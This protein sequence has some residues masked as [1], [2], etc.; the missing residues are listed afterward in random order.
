MPNPTLTASDIAHLISGLSDRHIFK[1]SPQQYADGFISAVLSIYPAPKLAK[2]LQSKFFVPNDSKYSDA[3]FFQNAAELSVSNHLK[4]SAAKGFETEKEVNPTNGYDVDNYFEAGPFRVSVEV[5]TPDE[6]KT[7]PGDWV[8][9]TLGRS[10]NYQQQYQKFAPLLA[11][12][13]PNKT[14]VPAK[15]KDCTA[16]DFL[17]SANTKFNPASGVD[18]LNVLF[19]A[20]GY[21]DNISNWYSYLFASEGLFTSESF[22]PPHEFR[23]VDVVVL[24]SL[25]Y[26]HEHCRAAHDWTLRDVFMLPCLNPHA[27][28]SRTREA[29]AGGLRVF[30][31]HLKE[32]VAFEKD[33][34]GVPPAA[35][36]DFK[37]LHYVRGYLD[38]PRFGRYFP[39]P[40]QDMDRAKLA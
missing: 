13:S 29:I 23:N 5:K 26:C 2:I 15:N 12:A 4:Q 19:V 40:L 27:R 36:D 3:V 7:T 31:H 6:Q 20:C 32:F 33:S 34:S 24:S 21:I 22:H 9:Q 8:L 39:V 37:V 10:P 1:R 28:S 14:V 38:T 16:K 30:E 25:R 11:P 17:I 35:F 18:D